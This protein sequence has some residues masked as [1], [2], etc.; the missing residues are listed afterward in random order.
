VPLHPKVRHLV[1]VLLS[2]IVRPFGATLGA[3][4]SPVTDSEVLVKALDELLSICT[5]TSTGNV[6]S[7]DL[8]TVGV[9][10]SSVPL[11]EVLDFRTQNY[12]LFQG[13]RRNV[14]SFAAEISALPRA[15]RDAAFRRRQEE[16]DNLSADIKRVSAQAWRKPASFALSLTGAAWSAL[17]G[18]PI[19]AVLALAA[20]ALGYASL[21]EPKLGAYSYVFRSERRFRR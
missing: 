16:L 19:G 17:T 12:D 3:E 13:Y 9:D 4:L 5:D 11:D 18:N 6:V 14:R 1:L 8:N 7:F 20:T 2:Q 10:V 15:A 21:A